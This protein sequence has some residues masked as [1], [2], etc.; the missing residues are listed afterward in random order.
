MKKSGR[1]VIVAAIIATVLGMSATAYAVSSNAATASFTASIRILRVISITNSSPLAFPE[2]EATD[3][4]QVVTVDA[5]SERAAGF[6][7]TGEPGEAVSVSVLQDTIQLANTAGN[8]IAV[9]SFTLGNGCADGTGSFD[10][11]SASLSCT[12]GA[13]ATVG[14][15]QAGGDYSGS[16]TLQVYYE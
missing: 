11:A 10:S 9:G 12:V 2:T 1:F 16:A 6:T 8:Q 13:S 7:I 4:Q 3:S 5:N 14:A 15:S